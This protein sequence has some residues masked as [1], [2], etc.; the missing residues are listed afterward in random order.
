MIEQLLSLNVRGLRDSKKRR[1]L[2]RWLKHFHN[3]NKSIIFLQETHATELDK[4]IWEKE[5]GSTVI[6][7]DYNT[8]SRGVAI[9]L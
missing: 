1:E 5:W 3:G 4:H 7:S 6:L 9:L 8:N 2:F